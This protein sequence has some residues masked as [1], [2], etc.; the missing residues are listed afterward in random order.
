MNILLVEDHVELGTLLQRR[1]TKAGHRI[2]W[3]TK[4]AQAIRYA[5]N[6]Q[7]DVI[8]LDIMLPDKSGF[9]VLNTLR[10]QGLTTPV[11]AL[12]ARTE[13]DDKVSMLELGADD[14][15]VKPFVFSELEARLRDLQ[16]S[17]MG[18]ATTT[19]HAGTLRVDSKARSKSYNDVVIEI[20]QREFC[21]LEL[22]LD[23]L[24]HT[25]SK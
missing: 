5:A 14:Y 12:T 6:G 18:Q 11:L 23:R 13:I 24:N 9:D 2:E 1:L 3:V 22:L 19:Y 21:L 8:L 25:V 7:W 20:I 4:G 17:S 10:Q 15:M 16:R